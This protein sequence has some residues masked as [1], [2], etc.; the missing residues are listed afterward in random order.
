MKSTIYILSIALIICLGACV[1]KNST[2]AADK[3][4][5]IRISTENRRYFEK[6]GRAWVP[7]SINYLPDYN[8]EN[9]ESYFKNFSEN[10][11]NAMR[12]WIS[13]RFLEIEDSVEGVYNEDKFKRIDKVLELA[14]TYGIYI[15][16]VLQHIRTISEKSDPAT[17]WANSKALATRFQNIQEYINADEGR[18]SYLRRAK[19]LSDRYKNNKH[20]YGWELWNEMDAVGNEQ[21]AIAFTKAMLNPVKAL[22]PNHLVTQTLGSMHSE[23][24]EKTYKMLAGIPGNE[25]LSIHRYLDQGN[26]WGQY[27]VVKGP[28]DILASDAVR[29]GLELTKGSPV[30]VMLN[31]VGAVDP[32]H[33]GPFSY[34][35]N[36]T[37]GILIHD[38]IFAPFFSGSAGS[39]SMWHWDHYI[40]PQKLWFHFQRFS[41]AIEG[42]DPVNEDFAPVFLETDGV[43]CYGLRGKN[44][45]I[46]W[47]R[48]TANN[49]KTELENALPA[50]P[51]ENF[52][53]SLEDINVNGIKKFSLY[54]P[55]NDK[56][57]RQ[58]NIEE[59]QIVVPSFKRSVVIIIE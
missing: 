35:P 51:K 15:K 56:R 47:C 7:V 41:N 8:F 55:W 46:I 3:E 4:G 21:E 57:T 38:M 37:L 58:F 11:G 39:G 27:N 44:T 24:A 48:D 36:D 9:I 20:I 6:D 52:R 30:P 14:E 17:A 53:L 10:G 1:P 5:Y 25:F 13:T 50:R 45:T 18:S 23:K 59:E 32:N 22:F 42:I 19:A 40:Y 28:V 34:Y 54:D 49:W 26:K 31:E 16:F 33:A 43:R 29:I 2:I 12:I